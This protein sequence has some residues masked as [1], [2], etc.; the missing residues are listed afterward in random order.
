MAARFAPNDYEMIAVGIGGPDLGA[1]DVGLRTAVVRT[2]ARSEPVSGSLM[3]IEKR[4]TPSN[5]GQI[6]LPLGL[7]TE[8]Q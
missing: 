1:I 4:F 6:F 7:G 3:P 2:E 8:A 5:L